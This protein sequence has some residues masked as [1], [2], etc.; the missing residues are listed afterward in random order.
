[1]ELEGKYIFLK[2]ELI[3]YSEDGWSLSNKEVIYEKK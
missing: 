2:G 1:M 3:R